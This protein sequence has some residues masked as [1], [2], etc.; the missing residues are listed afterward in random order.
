[1][2]KE[3]IKN[4]NDDVKAILENKE[5]QVV[6]L[7][8]F[9]NLASLWELN[10]HDAASLLGDP[11]ERTY[12]NWKEGKVGFVPTDTMRRISYLLGIHKALRILYRNPENLYKWI[13]QP[14]DYFNGQSPLERMVNGDMVE[15]AH[16]RKYI[17]GIRGT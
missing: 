7:K 3:E 8:A 6:G 15:M 1:M 12:Y 10:R 16:V 14:N 9:F 13:K 5:H 11:K 17:D 2:T 4:K